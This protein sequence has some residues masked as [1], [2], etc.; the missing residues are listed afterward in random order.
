MSIIKALNLG[1]SKGLNIVSV[2]GITYTP[3]DLQLNWFGSHY[4][5]FNKVKMTPEEYK[6]K[7]KVV[8]KR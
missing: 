5:S 3:E 4:A 8:D 7:W 1:T 6:D 2:K